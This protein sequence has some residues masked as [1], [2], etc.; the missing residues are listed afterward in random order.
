MMNFLSSQRLMMI[1]IEKNSKIHFLFDLSIRSLFEMNSLHSKQALSV[2]IAYSQS[3]MML[4]IRFICCQ[5]S[6][7][8]IRS[9]QLSCAS[10]ERRMIDEAVVISLAQDCS[11]A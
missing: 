8:S 11:V 7:I 6:S 2:Y 4:C 9:G 10:K 1:S 3:E 5:R